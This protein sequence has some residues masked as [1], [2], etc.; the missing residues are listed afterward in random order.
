M[1][2]LCVVCLLVCAEVEITLQRDGSEHGLVEGSE[3]TWSRCVYKYV[4]LSPYD[5]S[6]VHVICKISALAGCESHAFSSRL[7]CAASWP[8]TRCLMTAVPS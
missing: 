1:D 5:S 6:G 3:S 4:V 2:C 8:L 7:R